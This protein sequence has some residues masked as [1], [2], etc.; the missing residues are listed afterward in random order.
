MGIL[1]IGEKIIFNEDIE[2]RQD[3]S[4]LPFN[5]T[6]IGNSD[7]IRIRIAQADSLTLPSESKLYLE[8]VLL[9]TK[10]DYAD[11]IN[12]AFSYI[13]DEIRYELNGK[14]VD[15]VRN[16]GITSTLKSYSSTTL[17]ELAS[18]GNAGFYKPSKPWII[19][20]GVIDKTTKKFNVSIPL[21]FLMGFFEDYK[22]VLVNCKQELILIRSRTD[23][24]VLVATEATKEGCTVQLDK[25]MWVVP[26]IKVSNKVKLHLYNLIRQQKPLS[27]AF[28]SWE[29]HEFP[30]VPASNRF[31][32]HVKTSS[33][34]EKPRYVMLAF[35]T[36]RKDN[37]KANNSIFDN[38]DLRNVKLFL[39][40]VQYPYND[41]QLNFKEGKIATLFDMYINFQQSYYGYKK[42]LPLMDRTTFA[43]TPFVIIDTSNQNEVITEGG[44]DVRFEIET[45]AAIPEGTTA[46]ALFLHDKIV[47]YT[48]LTGVV[49]RY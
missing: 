40:D 23:N 18:L 2:S 33:V 13:F 32:W 28:R 41:L 26:Q 3:Y 45:N 47:A 25:V 1:D 49:E 14:E 30:N 5:I 34:L 44:V 42:S 19:T 27:M 12:N 24:N 6:R 20:N 22:K 43:E 29:L 37:Y 21:S 39:N 4:Y 35:Q 15:S 48:P 16:P 38:C 36:N 46:Y 17:A 31:S 11:F 8:G 10:D 9:K 7:E